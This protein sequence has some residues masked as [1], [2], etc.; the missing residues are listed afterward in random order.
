MFVNRFINRFRTQYG[1]GYWS[2]SGYLKEHIQ[3]AQE[4]IRDYEKAVS[5][6]IKRQ[7]YDGVVCGHI[8]QAA[9]KRIEGVDYYNTGDWVESCTAIVEHHSGK[10]EL[11]HWLD[12]PLR[13]EIEFVKKEKLQRKKKKKQEALA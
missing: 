2:F 4:Y 3:R 8:H 1:Y 13:Y 11:I 10:M 9:I 12:H 7:G 6:G 5:H